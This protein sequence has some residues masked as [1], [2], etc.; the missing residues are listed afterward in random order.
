[1]KNSGKANSAVEYARRFFSEE[2][3]QILD[4]IMNSSM[5]KAWEC[6]RWAEKMK[7]KNKDASDILLLDADREWTNFLRRDIVVHICETFKDDE[8]L[9]VLLS[10]DEQR[11]FVMEKNL[12]SVAFLRG[13][14]TD[15]HVNTASKALNNAMENHRCQRH[16][17]NHYFFPK[18]DFL[19]HVNRWMM[20]NFM[21]TESVFVDG[22][23]SKNSDTNLMEV[24][25]ILSKI[26]F[27]NKES[28]V[29]KNIE[30]TTQYPKTMQA[31]RD[32]WSQKVF[33]G[34]ANTMSDL[35]LRVVKF[36]EGVDPVANPFMT[37][38]AVWDVL[39]T[40]EDHDMLLISSWLNKPEDFM[41]YFNITNDFYGSLDTTHYENLSKILKNYPEICEMLRNIATEIFENENIEKKFMKREEDFL[42]SWNLLP[43]VT[44]LPNVNNNAKTKTVFQKFMDNDTEITYN[45]DDAASLV[46]SFRF[47]MREKRMD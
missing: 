19:R 8:F 9:P 40:R 3:V 47:L 33:L 13:N 16:E 11:R 37:E 10:N 42:H 41:E 20:D 25:R 15:N 36:S 34:I 44:S 38:L 18:Q 26:E 17:K 7:S 2:D 27:G 4:D 22:F 12:G 24:K 31:I 23:F 45:K 35:L 29:A 6:R 39:K 14:Y 30:A 1:M 43:N 46:R 32:F 21:M 28:L 5:D